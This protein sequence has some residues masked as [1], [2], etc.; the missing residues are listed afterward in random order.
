MCAGG[1]CLKPPAPWFNFSCL[2]LGGKPGSLRAELGA[3]W[4][5][6]GRLS[7][8]IS[9]RRVHT[10]S[11]EIHMHTDCQSVAFVLKRPKARVPPQYRALITGGQTLSV[12]VPA[13]DNNQD[14]HAGQRPWHAHCQPTTGQAIRL[15]AFCHSFYH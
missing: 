6:C 11:S 12:T 8:A 1:Y 5:G 15:V 3:V 10:G 4:V 2:L 14:P 9:E 7:K 13:V